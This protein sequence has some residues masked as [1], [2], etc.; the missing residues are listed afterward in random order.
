[1]T[2][3]NVKRI[4]LAEFAELNSLPYVTAYELFQNGDI[5]GIEIN[6]DT[7]L[8]EGWNSAKYPSS[9]EANTS[10]T[11]E[12]SKVPPKW[13]VPTYPAGYRTI[14]DNGSLAVE[15]ATEMLSEAAGS[16]WVKAKPVVIKR[17][18]SVLEKIRKL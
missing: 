4:P 9:S 3:V 1:M 2:N 14:L 13:G 18:L 7:I 17:G 12:P 5:T 10:T 15:K 16:A 8:V 11:G 6:K